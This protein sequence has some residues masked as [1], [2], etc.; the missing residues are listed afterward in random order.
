[1]EGSKEAFTHTMPQMAVTEVI[2]EILAESTTYIPYGF[3]GSIMEGISMDVIW[4]EYQK[5][6]M[7]HQKGLADEFERIWNDFMK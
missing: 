7:N 5:I 2:R 3:S 4:L 6:V 1:M